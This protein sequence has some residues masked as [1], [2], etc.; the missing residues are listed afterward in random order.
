MSIDTRAVRDALVTHAQAL[1]VFQ[2]V[3]AHEPKSKPGALLSCSLFS[4]RFTAASSGL[5]STSMLWVWHARITLA[6]LTEPQDDIDP[7]V[8]DAGAALLTSLSAGFTLG[9]L[10]RSIDVFGSQ[11]GVRLEG[12]SGYHTHDSTG[13][14][15]FMITI[16]IILN[17]VFTQG[18]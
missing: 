3:L 6:M 4:G 10:A 9:G 18:A 8:I 16:P 5:A 15:A 1:G 14:R 17:D 7:R 12:D 11:S 13:Y 2:N